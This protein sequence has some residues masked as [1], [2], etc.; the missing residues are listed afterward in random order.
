[1]QE[2]ARADCEVTA[3]PAASAAWGAAEGG[4][5]RCHPDL[6]LAA[7][8]PPAPADASISLLEHEEN[9][10]LQEL[11]AQYA[12]SN[13]RSMSGAALNASTS[14]DICDGGPEDDDS[15]S[16]NNS[17]T[18]PIP[19]LGAMAA[20][21]ASVGGGPGPG[22]STMSTRAM[23]SSRRLSISLAGTP[24]MASTPPTSS[25]SAAASPSKGLASSLPNGLL[26]PVARTISNTSSQL[27]VIAMLRSSVSGTSSAGGGGGGGSRIRRD[28]MSL[29]SP[30]S[31]PG[32]AP[33]IGPPLGV[34]LSS[35]GAAGL[36]A[37]AGAGA[38]AH[39]A[40]S[41]SLEDSKVLSRTKSMDLADHHLARLR[42]ITSGSR[43]GPMSASRR[44][45]A[46]LA[47]SVGPPSGGSGVGA[48]GAGGPGSQGVMMGMGGEA[49]ST[50]RSGA[51]RSG[52]AA[53]APSPSV[54]STYLTPRRRASYTVSGG[55]QGVGGAGPSSNLSSG[56]LQV[57]V[58]P[59]SQPPSAANGPR[60][61]AASRRASYRV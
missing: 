39:I 25:S 11:A 40:D 21:N 1:M 22:L 42:S 13:S 17:G 2:V 19:T 49:S 14:Q 7:I 60:P 24:G 15:S 27:N 47:I 38:G 43:S 45:G 33:A 6:H 20:A 32:P 44:S 18:L 58:P 51:V 56:Q 61:A 26:A 52:E 37:A 59:S 55:L 50:P 10:E 5:G 3:P 35:S 57:P 23:P 8:L 9:I 30:S 53:W 36:G 41:L 31:P 46:Q 16:N 54:P 29:L 28:S 4:N 34:R 12:R 48:G